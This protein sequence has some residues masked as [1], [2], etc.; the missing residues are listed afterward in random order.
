MMSVSEPTKRA[1]QYVKNT[2]GGA[3]KAIFIDDY[4]P[5]GELLWNS[6]QSL[7]REDGNGRIW[8]TDDGK[9]ILAE[10]EENT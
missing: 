1:L 6:L 7:V 9:K 8:L 4:E 5:V 3:T 10:S 2:N